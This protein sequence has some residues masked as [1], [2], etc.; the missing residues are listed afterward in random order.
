LLLLR[1]KISVTV[2]GV[3]NMKD[4][5][6]S[7]GIAVVAILIG[8]AYNHAVRACGSTNFAS[9]NFWVASS[10]GSDSNPGTSVGLPFATISHTQT[11]L[12]AQTNAITSRT[13]CLITGTYNFAGANWSFTSA[14]S[15]ERWLPYSGQGLVIIDG[16][17]SGTTNTNQVLINGVTGLVLEGLVFQ[18]WS[19]AHVRTGT[20]DTI[21]LITNGTGQTIRWNSFLNS[22]GFSIGANG[23]AS[24]SITSNTFNGQQTGA[25]NGATAAYNDIN[26]YGG[27]HDNTISHNL[28]E[29][30]Q[31]G[32]IASADAGNNNIYD[33]NLLVNDL[34]GCFDN[35]TLYMLN[36]N[37]TDTG[38]QITNNVV[39]GN[40]PNAGTI[41]TVYLDDSMSNV[42]VQGN[43]CSHCG[44][45]F[46]QYHAGQNNVV[47][48]NIIDA[49]SI[50]TGMNLYQSGGVGTQT[51][52]GGNTFTNNII[53]TSGN[54][55]TLWIGNTTGV[56]FPTVTNNDYWSVTGATANTSA[57]PPGSPDSNPQT[58]NPL[59]GNPSANNYVIGGGSL[60][61]SAPVSFPVLPTDQGPVAYAP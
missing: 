52:M 38:N 5:L 56:T 47:K 20:L 43:I 13:A 41:K 14:D 18:N 16:G 9:C 27:A 33:R 40:I 57:G 31:C 17:S 29:N 21:M 2:V 39:R 7:V 51:G 44:D 30:G 1:R 59:F 26:L 50:G 32:G 58:Q 49:S 23:L 36:R 53:Y 11:V 34:I 10:G 3:I 19:T 25:P 12:Q 42:L 54:F 60:V 28:L 4:F 15:N 22:W 35:G 24:S 61:L 46:M 37:A 55:P 6:R 8:L 48:N 45:Y